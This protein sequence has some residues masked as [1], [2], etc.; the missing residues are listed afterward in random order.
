M[1]SISIL[2]ASV[3]ASLLIPTAFAENPATM[4]LSVGFSIT[5]CGLS[6]PEQPICYSLG[7]GP[8]LNI[9]I[10][11]NTCAP[12]CQGASLFGYDQNGKSFSGSISVVDAGLSNNG[13]E[14]YTLTATIDPPTLS[15]Q[16]TSVIMTLNQP[17]VTDSIQFSG[18][19]LVVTESCQ[20]EIPSSCATF[21]QLIHSDTSNR[22]MERRVILKP[23]RKPSS[24][25]T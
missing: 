2:L 15:Q 21:D 7:S 19:P 5:K 1:K 12:D 22:T 6:P 4:K 3:C 14:V 20:P 9:E 23:G 18:A 10:P 24:V 8:P 25:S 13:S 17:R 11:I 16:S